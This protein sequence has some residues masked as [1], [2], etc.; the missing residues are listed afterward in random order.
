V[1]SAVVTGFA[2]AEKS[3]PERISEL[4]EQIG[5]HNHRYYTLDA[6]EVSDATYDGLMNEL[7]A[8]EKAHPELITPDSPTQRV[9]AAPA[10]K[11]ERVTH[12]QQMLSL[13][14]VFNDDELALFDERV[15]KLL[16]V[17]E[18]A[19][20]CEPKMDGLAIELVYE[21]GVF[22]QGSTRGDGTV[23]EDVTPNLRT[24][25]NLPLK[26]KGAAVKLLELRG[27]V[28][29]RRADFLKM[30]SEREAAG[31]PTFVNPRNSAAG[32]LRQLDPR[33]TAQR[34]LSVIV[35]EVGVVDGV[36]FKTHGEKLDWLG[37]AGLPTNPRRYAAKGLAGVRAAYADMLKDRHAL[38]YEVDGLVVKVDD[39]DHRARLGQVSRSPRW[40]VAYKFP[41]EE[42]E[43]HLASIEVSVGRT[44]AITPYA[45]FDPPVFVGGV[46]VTTATLHNEDEVKRKG[47]LVGDWVFLRRAGDVIPEVVKPIESRRDGTERAF[48]MPK[49]CPVCGAEALR[50][51]AVLRC[52]NGSCPA[53]LQGR[54][55]H[56][57]S[58]ESMDIEGLGEKLAA[59]LVA[60]GQVKSPADLYRLTLEALIELERMGEKSAQNLLDN[61][62]KSKAPAL[63]R[64]IHALGIPQVG[65]AT[66]RALALAFK[67]M[68]ALI[69]ATEERLQDVRDVGPEVA[70]DVRAFFESPANRAWVQA[71]LDAGVTP[72]PPE[73]AQGGVFQGKSVVIT[74]TL[75]AMGRDE[76]KEEIERRG[77]RVSGSVSKKTDMLVA[78]A[79]AGSKLKKATELGVRVIDEA[80]FLK[81]I[82]R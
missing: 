7:L 11:F 48:V 40:A 24:I 51:G 63:R 62:Q 27:E 71:L 22:V 6:P 42:V 76:A 39:E 56:F 31:E 15:R 26:L 65:E 72:L 25:R 28:F 46:T 13:G 33:S 64:F 41:P 82:G 55:Q 81:L 36:T 12:R 57:A 45:I 49:V 5:Y 52:T 35:Y 69:D 47:V 21:G 66:A 34:P 80:E 10:E 1:S 70:K 14:N 3:P 43:A 29:I 16:G 37:S 9:G 58:R 2:V 30:N 23:G 38:P 50:T 78:G 8:L 74:G 79:E 61:I 44:G 53:Q 18:V 20:I 59:Q 32:S 60:H 54:L 68:P 73:D 77:G 17:E 75:E 19:Y 4:R 67:S